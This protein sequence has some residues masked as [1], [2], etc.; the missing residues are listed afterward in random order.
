MNLL[1]TIPA[2]A[3]LILG[4]A[5]GGGGSDGGVTNPPASNI[6]PAANAGADKVVDELS[7]VALAG[8]GVDPDGSISSFAWSQTAGTSVTIENASASSASFVAPEIEDVEVLVFQLLVTDNKGATAK[9]IVEIT[10]NNVN[11]TPN[12]IAGTDQSADENTG[13]TLIGSGSN[14]SDGTIVSYQWT[15]VSGIPVILNSAD[16][17]N[18]QFVAPPVDAATTLE[19]S[20]TV[21]DNKGAT[22]ID[23]VSVTVN[24]VV[25]P[26]VSPIANAGDDQTVDEKSAVMLDGG[27]SDADGT[28]E[29]YSW[30]QMSGVDVELTDADTQTLSFVA[31]NIEEG[32]ADV[33]LVFTL[34]VTDNEGATHTDN[35]TVFVTALDN[36]V[37]L[38]VAGEDQA[39]EEQSKI[40][41]VGTAEDA[42]GEIVGY[43]WTQT[44]G[45]MA[46]L[47]NPKSD[48]LTIFAPHIDATEVLTF[49]LTVEDN[50]GGLGTDTLDITL[51]PLIADFTLAGDEK[52]A[53]FAIGDISEFDINIYIEGDENIDAISD[54]GVFTRSYIESTNPQELPDGSDTI[55]KRLSYVMNTLS[56]STTRY[57]AYQ[58]PDD[59]ANPRDEIGIFE[60]NAGKVY[61]LGYSDTGVDGVSGMLVPGEPAIGY[62]RTITYIKHR[63][64]SDSTDGIDDAKDVDVVQTFK[65]NET[66]VVKTALG[67]FE[68]Y[69]LQVN[70]T[71]TDDDETVDSQV[72]TYWLYPALGIIKAEFTQTLGSSTP[73]SETELRYT[74]KTTTLAH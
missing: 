52:L 50:E 47:R 62:D 43:S 30:V 72:G 28:V 20:L 15:Q 14:D 36:V 21:T 55:T 11:K 1:R 40:I 22:A 54:D 56:V 27:G 23:T 67:N 73:V 53:R 39:V 29:S 41:L 18:S 3:F 10:V 49:E 74:L 71:E 17:V 60:Y 35:V 2:L 31:P 6:K 58:I 33:T 37:P 38:V 64:D 61:A 9:D 24:N 65:I 70:Y 69:K 59:K 45:P 48:T 19:F 44:A 13:V 25:V 4:T 66:E 68:A 5:C 34:T 16:S 63:Y 8:S 46:V 26:N 42:D 51:S 32:G 57:E 7:S 12:A